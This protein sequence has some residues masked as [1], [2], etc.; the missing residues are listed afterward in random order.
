MNLHYKKLS[1]LAFIAFFSFTM[2]SYAQTSNEEFK[3]SGNFWGYSFGDYSYKL[4]GDSL[5]RGGGNVAYK[6][7]APTA[8]NPDPNS[9]PNTN[10]FQ[11]RRAYLGY[12]YN[13]SPKFSAYAVLAHEELG[14][15]PGTNLDAGG[16]NSVYLKYLYLKWADI[17]PKSNLI[18]GQ[19][20]TLSFATANNTEPLW[21]YRSVA[22]TI[23]D[24]HNIDASSDMGVSLQGTAWSAKEGDKPM[25]LGYMVQVGNGNSAKPENDI[26]KKVR[27][28]VYMKLLDQ[29][30]TLGLY[31]DYNIKQ[32]QP[33]HI[34]TTT[35]KA[36]AHYRTDWF[37]VGAEVFQQTSSNG[38]IF[39][40]STT[41]ASADT[42][43]CV[44]F[45]VSLFGSSRIIKD[46]LNFFANVAYYSPDTKFNSSAY[47]YISTITGGNNSTTS[48]YTQTFLVAGFDYTPN[49]RIHI[50]PNIWYSQY[51]TTASA[52]LSGVSGG[53]DYSTRQKTDYDLVARVTFY[54]IF[55][56]AKKVSNNGMDY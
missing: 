21:G 30:L 31:G 52:N 50:M 55:N 53:A 41:A 32:Y 28:N 19:M 11:I 46:K 49:P 20:P 1:L 17:F 39:W 6:G 47:K 22:R 43:D 25:L 10:M 35:L 44:Q 29:K 7:T 15:T 3:P 9:N 8:A 51:N 42:A 26:F 54:Y 5:A 13:F 16:S 40:T 33:Y 56:S 23:M 48:F 18:I 24:M 12:D 4:H 36:Y 2:K 14:G 34:A 27:G 45:G 37:S 38:D